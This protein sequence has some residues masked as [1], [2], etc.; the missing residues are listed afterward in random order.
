MRTILIVV[1]VAL[2]VG[3]SGVQM[4]PPYRMALE[5]SAITT[6]ELNERCQTGDA[7]ACKEGLAEASRTLNLLVDG[8]HAVSEVQ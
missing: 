6:A 7:E 8:L 5:M 2:C 3:C 1:L 4:S